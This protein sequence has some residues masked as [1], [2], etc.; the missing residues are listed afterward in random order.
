M[1]IKEPEVICFALFIQDK[2]MHSASHEY[3]H[4]DSA[5]LTGIQFIKI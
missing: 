3:R 1:K 2:H 5:R 4:G